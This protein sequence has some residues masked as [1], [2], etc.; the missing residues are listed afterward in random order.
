MF[1]KPSSSS[2]LGEHRLPPSTEHSDRASIGILP[3]ETVVQPVRSPGGQPDHGRTSQSLSSPSDCQLCWGPASL[4]D[5]CDAKAA[6][7]KINALTR[8]RASGSLT[9]ENHGETP[10]LCCCPRTCGWSVS[11][12]WGSSSIMGVQSR[13]SP[14]P[15]P[16]LPPRVTLVC[17]G[18]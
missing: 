16:L 8:L 12:G 1:P 5:V 13:A 9:Q 7:E 18:L 10:W 11:S 2:S 3:D 17:R 6:R 4:G 15:H 14:P